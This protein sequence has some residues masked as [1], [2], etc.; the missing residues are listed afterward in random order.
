MPALQ[1]ICALIAVLDHLGPFQPFHDDAFRYHYIY[2]CKLSIQHPLI[3]HLHFIM[4]ITDYWPLAR[5]YSIWNATEAAL[6]FWTADLKVHGLSSVIEQ[7]YNAFFYTTSMHLLCQQSEEVLFSHFM[8]MLN[9]VFE[10]KLTLEDEEYERGSE[11][12]NIPTPLTC[13]PRIHHV[14]SHDNISFDTTTPCSTGTS[15]SH[16]MPF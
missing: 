6:Q 2:V 12:F 5:E 11:K 7:V 8:T 13:T 15:P 1:R 3:L 14:S 10:S 16:H 4:N 9:A